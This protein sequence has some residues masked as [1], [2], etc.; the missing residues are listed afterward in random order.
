MDKYHTSNVKY[1]YK[2]RYKLPNL[3]QQED[4]NCAISSSYYIS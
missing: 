2:L 1:Y 3:T 4:D